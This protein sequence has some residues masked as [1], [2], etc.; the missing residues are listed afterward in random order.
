MPVR[1]LK[2]S[3][4]NVTGLFFSRKLGRLVQFDSML[5]R[6]FILLLDMHTAVGS[7]AEQPMKVDWLDREGVSQV[8]VPDFL[9][10][11][12]G[13]VFLGRRIWRPWIVE[14]K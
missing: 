6:D 2:N 13:D 11:F 1:A 14:T 7:F 9:I 5:E 3:Y 4:R 12:T 10:S 8:Y